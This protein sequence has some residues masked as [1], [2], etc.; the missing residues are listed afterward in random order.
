MFLRAESLKGSCSVVMNGVLVALA[1]K[2]ANL[3]LAGFQ[4]FAW[5]MSIFSSFIMSLRILNWAVS[6]LWFISRRIV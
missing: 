3:Q 6:F 4:M 2:N 1:A 5:T